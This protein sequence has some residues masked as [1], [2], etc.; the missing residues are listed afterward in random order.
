M[1]FYELL[2]SDSSL[3]GKKP[4]VGCGYEATTIGESSEDQDGLKQ[5]FGGKVIEL[6]FHFIEPFLYSTHRYQYMKCVKY[7]ASS[8]GCREKDSFLA[9]HEIPL[10]F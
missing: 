10:Y 6:S 1:L 2:I 4:L 9:L 3:R 5:N 7:C 8:W